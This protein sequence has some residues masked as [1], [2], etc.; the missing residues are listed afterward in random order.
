MIAKYVGDGAFLHGVPARD[1]DESEWDALTDE[2]RA[3]AVERGLYR[4]SGARRRS[5][6]EPA[7]ETP[8]EP[9]KSG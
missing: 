4:V 6:E 5:D 9:A 3:A 8:I 1:L 2:E 7:A